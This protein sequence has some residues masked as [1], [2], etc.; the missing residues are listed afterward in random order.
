[1]SRPEAERELREALLALRRAVVRNTLARRGLR[2]S[3]EAL[4]SLDLDSPL[5]PYLPDRIR[6]DQLEPTTRRAR[7]VAWLRRRLAWRP[8]R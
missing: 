3:Q 2:I 6:K 7:L 1:M 5:E 4:Q 8:W